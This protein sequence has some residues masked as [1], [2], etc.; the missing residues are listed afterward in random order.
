MS[1]AT[2]RIRIGLQRGVARADTFI[3]IIVLLAAGWRAGD[4]HWISAVGLGVVGVVLVIASGDFAWRK[5][6]AAATRD[7]ARK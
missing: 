1:R 3:A 4:G 5:G 7:D 2:D 6:Y